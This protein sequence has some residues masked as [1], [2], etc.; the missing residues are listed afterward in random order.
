MSVLL[1]EAQWRSPFYWPCC[2][3]ADDASG[4]ERK[5]ADSVALSVES[6]NGPHTGARM[7]LAALLNKCIYGI[8]TD[9]V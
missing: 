8:T 9:F 6:R 4:D 2:A 5:A 3:A 7:T 1:E